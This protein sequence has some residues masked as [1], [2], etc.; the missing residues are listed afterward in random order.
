MARSSKLRL[1]S[2]VVLP[3]LTPAQNKPFAEVLVDTGLPL[4][5]EIY[6]YTIPDFLDGECVEGALVQVDFHGNKK[7]GYVLSRSDQS[8]VTGTLKS[9]EKVLSHFPIYSG[10][11]RVLIESCARRYGS[12][13]WSI[14]ARIITAP[15]AKV[16]KAF[17]FLSISS[18]SHEPKMSNKEIIREFRYFQP[19]EPMDEQIL[20]HIRKSSSSQILIVTPDGRDI[21]ILSLAISEEFEI[22]F[23][24]STIPAHERYRNYLDALH[25]V[26]GI[27]IGN[28][29]AIF[30]P[31]GGE[32]EIFILN[33]NDRAHYESHFPGWNTRDVAI[34]RSSTSSCIFISAFPSLEIARLMEVDWISSP[35][36]RSRHQIALSTTAQS[37]SDILNLKS[38]IQSGDVLVI[39]GEGGYVTAISCAKCRSLARCSCG[40]K[41]IR[42]KNEENPSCALCEKE[43]LQWSCDYCAHSKIFEFA[44]GSDR[45]GYEIGR[46]LPGVPIETNSIDSPLYR[47]TPKMDSDNCVV[48]SHAYEIPVGKFTAISIRG[49]ESL[50]SQV[51]LRSEE[52]SL[53]LLSEVLTNLTKEGTLIVNLTTSHPIYQSLLR[54][55]FHR[56]SEALLQER[57]SLQLTPYVRFSILWGSEEEL[58]P[59]AEAASRNEIFIHVAFEAHGEDSR[60][61]YR[62]KVETGDKLGEYFSELSRLRLLKKGKPLRYRID[63]FDITFTS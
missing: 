57:K 63:P 14:I 41:L 50:L 52:L 9:I 61:I 19:H 11:L 56:V 42:N 16:E 49:T 38:A 13:H 30:T 26:P 35:L 25:G 18:E 59:I 27:Y 47:F 45:Q 23:L 12:N 58:E 20:T 55:E 2:E 51:G 62:S 54:G 44:K 60:I 6:T 3:K 36:A 43:Y 48:V 8:E 31:M 24:N 21:E 29:S 7:R 10:E 46:A 39:V 53:R 1:T 15:I 28:R 33:D 22:K 4:V 32:H 40:G 17:E 5:H 34:L 37:G